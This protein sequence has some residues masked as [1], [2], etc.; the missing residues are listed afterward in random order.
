MSIVHRL[1]IERQQTMLMERGGGQTQTACTDQEPEA[2]SQL[3]GS[4]FP[5]DNRSA[6]SSGDRQNSRVPVG[7]VSQAVQPDAL[8]TIQPAVSSTTSQSDTVRPSQDRFLSCSKACV[9]ADSTRC[10]RLDAAT[11]LSLCARYALKVPPEMADAARKKGLC[12]YTIFIDK[13]RSLG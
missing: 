5:E 7:A 10:G 13:L 12:S 3:V 4:V 1:Q 2:L 8:T 9:R 6:F 11:M